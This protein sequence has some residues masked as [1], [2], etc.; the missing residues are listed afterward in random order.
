MPYPTLYTF[1]RCP[2][3][4]RARM[5]LWYAGIG[6]RIREIT[7]KQKPQAMLDA[8]PKGTVPVLVLEDGT[9]IDESIDIMRWS[10]LHADPQNWCDSNYQIQSDRF[11]LV[12][13]N[14]FKPLLDNYKYPQSSEKQD[15]IYYRNQI[16]PYLQTL[17]Q[18]L[19]DYQFLFGDKINIADVA[20]FPFI[21]QFAMVD[22]TWFDQAPYPHL[23]QWL[24]AFINS[25]LFQSVMQKYQAWE[26]QEEPILI[27][28]D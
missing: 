24:Q 25:D 5:A 4:I 11:I 28:H 15:P 12:N 14:E 26:G 13:D 1:R 17:N 6:V 9:V 23:Q 27:R 7:L 21:R 16:K 22:K 8:S 19:S 10:L 2:Y 18:Q 3:A 20:L